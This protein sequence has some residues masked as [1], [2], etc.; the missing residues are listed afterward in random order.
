MFGGIFA[1][2][3]EGAQ[4]HSSLNLIQLHSLCSHTLTDG[5]LGSISVQR[6]KH[7]PGEQNLPNR[8]PLHVVAAI[9]PFNH[10]LNQVVHKIAPSIATNNSMVLKPSMQTPLAAHYVVQSATECGLPAKM[11][12]VVCGSAFEVAETLVSSD[13]GEI[14]TF[15]DGNKVGRRIAS[16][17]GYKR[18]VLEPGVI[19]IWRD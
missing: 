14:I 1:V 9:T 7:W 4:T 6:E 12:D 3:Q 16:L 2:L 19:V 13:Q 18:L 8:L 15:T 10:S 5:W 17:G 11:V